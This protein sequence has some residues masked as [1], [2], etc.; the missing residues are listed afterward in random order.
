MIGNIIRANT[1]HAISMAPNMRDADSQEV[2]AS[3]GLTP[4]ETLLCELKQSTV[5]WSWVIDGEVACMFGVVRYGLFGDVCYPWFLT[6]PLVE[7]H[8]RQF[9]RA[10]KTILPELLCLF[11]KMEGMVDARYNLSIRWLRWLGAEIDAPIP[12]G[13]EK[14]P[15]CKF[16]L[17]DRIGYFNRDNAR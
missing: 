4:L 8:A 10:C 3:H 9:A 6:T 17:G 16:Y 13:V 7:V 14:K 2:R 11:P 5:A 12:W 15:F 1:D